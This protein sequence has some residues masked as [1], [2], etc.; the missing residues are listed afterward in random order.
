[1][2]VCSATLSLNHLARPAQ[3]KDGPWGLV[4]VGIRCGL[5]DGLRRFHDEVRGA[6]RGG[7]L[8][9]KLSSLIW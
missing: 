3:L 1:V 8:D 2:I 9:Q 4:M 6:G 5:F 7:I